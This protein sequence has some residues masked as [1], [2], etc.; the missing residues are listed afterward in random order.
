MLFVGTNET[1]VPPA[2]SHRGVEVTLNQRRG[3]ARAHRG[4]GV[5][6]GRT[7]WAQ[8]P[9]KCV[10]RARTPPDGPSTA[11]VRRE[12]FTRAR[13]LFLAGHTLGLRMAPFQ[14]LDAPT[15]SP[16]HG[17]SPC[18]PHYSNFSCG[19]VFFNLQS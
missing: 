2:S 12:F 10:V 14:P 9:A 11:V 8:Q 15:G 3:R 18:L 17:A 7:W 1:G 5:S 6:K 4:H 16:Q 13:P 19:S